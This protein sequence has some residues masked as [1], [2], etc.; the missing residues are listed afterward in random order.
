MNEALKLLALVDK[1]NNLPGLRTG[2]SQKAHSFVV[3]IVAVVVVVAGAVVVFE[4]N[5]PKQTGSKQAVGFGHD[6]ISSAPS[7]NNRHSFTT[8]CPPPGGRPIPS[9][10]LRS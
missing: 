1:F 5:P 10:S 7:A 6:V 8:A 2:T 9:R 3:V 4:N